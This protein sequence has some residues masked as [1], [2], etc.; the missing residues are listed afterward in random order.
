MIE[1]VSRWRIVLLVPLLAA[2]S[3]WH[4]YYRNGS[5]TQ[6]YQPLSFYHFGIDTTPL[7]I[8]FQAAPLKSLASQVENVVARIVGLLADSREDHHSRGT[9]L[10]LE[11]SIP[12]LSAN[13]TNDS[14][15]AWTDSAPCWLE[16]RSLNLS[17]GCQ[18]GR[19]NP[20]KQFMQSCPELAT[21]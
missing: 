1:L 8:C 10:D 18:Q 19:S 12:R 2:P 13:S 4:M 11:P 15:V 17:K 9:C 21:A 16:N 7:F 3:P 6:P 14:N 20:R 5:T